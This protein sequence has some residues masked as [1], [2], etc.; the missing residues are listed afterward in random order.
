MVRFSSV[1]VGLYGSTAVIQPMS[2]RSDFLTE[3][4][5]Q[6]K[7]QG[8]KTS[9]FCFMAPWTSISQSHISAACSEVSK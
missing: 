4:R 5:Y 9:S 8:S 6:G 7:M 1:M 3:A 2:T